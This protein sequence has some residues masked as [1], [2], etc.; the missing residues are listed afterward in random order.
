MKLAVLL[1]LLAI[2]A[3]SYCPQGPNGCRP[4][5]K[6]KNCRTAQCYRCGINEVFNP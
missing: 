1:L 3:M 5:A 6:I 2:T 4:A